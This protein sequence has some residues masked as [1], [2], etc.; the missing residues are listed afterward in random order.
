MGVS[1]ISNKQIKALNLRPVAAANMVKTRENI[2]ALWDVFTAHI[3]EEVS[4]RGKCSLVAVKSGD[5]FQLFLED[6][7]SKRI[8]GIADPLKIADRMLEKGIAKIEFLET[9]DTFCSASSVEKVLLA[10]LSNGFAPYHETGVFVLDDYF[11]D[12]AQ[13]GLPL[14]SG[15]D[16]RLAETTPIS[17]D[18]FRS[19]VQGSSSAEAIIGILHRQVIPH[20][21][22]AELL[23]FIMTLMTKARW[24][25]ES[26]KKDIDS[27][28]IIR[29]AVYKLDFSERQ[30]RTVIK[31]MMGV[32]NTLNEKDI[33][34]AIKTWN[35]V[36]EL[37][38][39]EEK[40]I[41]IRTMMDVANK[42]SNA[43]LSKESRN[44]NSAV[45]IWTAVY[46]LGSENDKHRVIL[47][48]MNVANIL[49]EK[50]IDSAIK[51]WKAVYELRPEEAKQIV[52]LTMMDVANKLNEKDVNSA[53]KIWK[54][55][56]E[57]RPEEAKQ[58]VILTMMDVANKLNEEDVNSAI[59]IWKAVYELIPEEEKPIVIRTMMDVA[60]KL[61]KKDVDSAIKIWKAVYEL[62]SEED[63]Q[64]AILTIMN[65][66][67]QNRPFCEQAIGV[68]END[69]SDYF[70][71]R[72]LAELYYH[73]GKFQDTINLVDSSGRN[74]PNILSQKA[75]A[76][77]KMRRYN[78]AIKLSSQII[79]DYT[80][81]S[82][83]TAEEARGLIN[84]L[85]CR[86]YCY[87]EGN[88]NNGAPHNPQQAI[89]DFIEA[90]RVAKKNNSPIP[91]RAY[92]GL[93]YVYDCQGK[94]PEAQAAFAQA[95]KLDPGNVKALKKGK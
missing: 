8:G 17:V 47:T 44:I 81:K 37:I 45:K 84:A 7:D 39:E 19:V 94:K 64:R 59:K 11:V 77:R 12:K 48:M 87:H 54:A 14:L 69:P 60:N 6:A 4:T 61:N 82:P 23:P 36:Y 46:E 10:V 85:C 89:G 21:P 24:F 83:L 90:I 70:K 30:N 29:V 1:A 72:I 80:D 92:S 93:G 5:S 15:V 67:S 50:D 91:P 35:A 41:V 73:A 9:V 95:L 56:Y 3:F 33:D 53:I 52:I 43:S 38:P 20:Y 88:G 75:D 16:Y 62:G 34:S 32:A 22:K 63:K 51:I 18:E 66:A 40:P 2:R 68:F 76:L 27:A 65:V 79:I 25:F 55:V 28:N 78:E 26:E 71:I 86:G 42:F 58:I 74:G 57:L 49:N 13:N 31:T